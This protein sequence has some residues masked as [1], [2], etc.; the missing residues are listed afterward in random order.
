MQNIFEKF[1]IQ[2]SSVDG[3]TKRQIHEI[4]FLLDSDD[5]GVFATVTDRNLQEIEVNYTHFH[6]LSREILKSIDEIR[7]QDSARFH[8]N[9]GE[10]R[11]YLKEY[12]YLTSLIVQSEFLIKENTMERFS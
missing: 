7:R 1:K 4:R 5:E 6:G 9:R 11:C 2:S 3:I 12:P 10:D 8:W